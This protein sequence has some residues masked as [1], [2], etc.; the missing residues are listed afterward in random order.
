MENTFLYLIIDNRPNG[1]PRNKM[2]KCITEDQENS[3][4]YSNKA[5]SGFPPLKRST[6]FIKDSKADILCYCEP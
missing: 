2:Q 4:L 6:N 5:G 3:P 1:T